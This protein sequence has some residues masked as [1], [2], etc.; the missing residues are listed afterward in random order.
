MDESMISAFDLSTMPASTLRPTVN[1]MSSH[2]F[3]GLASICMI[4]RSLVTGVYAPKVFSALRLMCVS[5][6]YLS[7]APNDQRKPA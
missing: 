1:T 4:V 7:Y 3:L 6:V 5:N 2:R